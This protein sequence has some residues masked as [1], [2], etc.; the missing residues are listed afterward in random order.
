M[1]KKILLSPVG[2]SDPMPE[3]NDHDGAMIHICRVYKVDKV[4]MY[5]S[6]EILEKHTL[7]NRYVYCLNKLSE[8]IGKNIEYEIIKRENLID[9]WNFDYFYDEFNDILKT[10]ENKLDS[11]D[12]L[13]INV[14]SGT[15]EMMSSLVVLSAM[16]NIRCR[17]IQV[18][19]PDKKMNTHIHS[20]DYILEKR[21]SDNQ[22]NN[23]NFV[24]RCIEL[25]SRPLINIANEKIIKEHIKSY[26]YQAAKTVA[27]SMPEYETKEYK[28]LINLAYERYLLNECR[29]SS[30]I[31][32]NNIDESKVFPQCSN[33]EWRTFFEY[34]LTLDI[35]IKRHE[36]GDF[37]RAIS[38]VIFELF[39]R[40]LNKYE[41]FD[42]GNYTHRD[43]NDIIR[44]DKEKL[45]PEYIQYLENANGGQFDYRGYVKSVHLK[46]IIIRCQSTSK[47]KGLVKLVKDLREIEGKMRNLA[48]HTMVC[49]TD[50]IVKKRT[51]YN[52]EQIMDKIKK[53]FEY[54]TANI[55]ADDWNSYDVMNDEIISKM[56]Y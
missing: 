50:E 4:Y 7:D 30:L 40:I 51:G 10:L 32:E 9:V 13:L 24:N 25:K 18:T 54:T 17:C 23:D 19:T 3:S 38:P 22:D 55:N 45:K 1:N 6:K 12:E 47:I 33:D 37:V 39:N 21:W 43:R 20:D 11:T 26:D 49:V 14:T 46:D 27:D 53:A 48:A 31:D 34:T 52:C 36:Y 35:R 5:M 2:G 15:A 16:C 44:W 28:H 56:T 8:L 41:N 42:L 29:I